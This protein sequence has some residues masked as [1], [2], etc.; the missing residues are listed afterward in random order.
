MALENKWINYPAMNWENIVEAISHYTARG[1]EYI[2]VPWVV[3]EKTTLMTMPKDATPIYCELMDERNVLVGSA[4]QGFLEIRKS[5]KP[6]QLYCSMSPCFRG[7]K[8]VQPGFRQL[9]FMKVELFSL[10]ED[11]NVVLNMLGDALSFFDAKFKFGSRHNLKTKNINENQYDID[12]RDKEI[13]SYGF[14]S[15]E[16][17]SWAYGTGLAEPRFTELLR[18]H[19][20]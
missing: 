18:D 11:R 8:S 12:L 10:T 3:S 7:E 9:T 1:Y 19:D 15:V 4:E 6:N 5:L 2:E 16:G 14:R 13:G 17:V 20:R